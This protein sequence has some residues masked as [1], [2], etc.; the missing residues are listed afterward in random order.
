MERPTNIFS[1]Q[2]PLAAEGLDGKCGYCSRKLAS[3]AFIYSSAK[4][5]CG[6]AW[7]LQRALLDSQQALA[8]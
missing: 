4:P 7:C 3:V 2:R 6:S 1:L 5:S 8:A